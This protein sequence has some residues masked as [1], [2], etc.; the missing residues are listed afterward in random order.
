MEGWTDGP[1]FIGPFQLLP[2]GPIIII[3]IM[4]IILII[5]AI[6]MIATVKLIKILSVIILPK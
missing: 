2:G 4:T 1:Y 5:I 3:L 6:I